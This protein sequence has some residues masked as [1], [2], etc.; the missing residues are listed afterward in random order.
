MSSGGCAGGPFYA[1]QRQPRERLARAGL[2]LEPP[3]EQVQGRRVRDDRVQQVV[4]RAR[5][6][7]GVEHLR[8]AARERRG[9]RLVRGAV[10]QA[11]LDEHLEP[12]AGARG[13]R[14][15]G[16][17]GEP[18]DGAVVDQAADAVRGGVRAEADARAE[19]AVGE[20]RICG[21][22]AED[23][24]VDGVH[25]AMIAVAHAISAVRRRAAS[26]TLESMSPAFVLGVLAGL[27]VAMPVGPVGVLLLRSGLVDGV[28]VAVAAACGIATVDLLYAVVA[29]AVG[30]PVS[31]VVGEHAALVRG[32]SAAVLVAI[33]DRR[34]RRR[35][36]P[37]S[38]RPGRRTGRC[39]RRAPTGGSSR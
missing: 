19:V 6:V 25:T 16:H 28:R 33:G 24:V 20:P 22:L 38:A 12:G 1:A 21:Q 4:V 15:R 10:G 11:H 3:D 13:G 17:D 7:H 18:A 29:V 35:H 30:T 26:A 34:A 5:D 9:E 2:A 23:C 36:A 32:V 31:R 8:E 14:R 27:S 37:G 39:R